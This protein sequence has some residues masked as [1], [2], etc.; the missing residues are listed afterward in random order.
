[1]NILDLIS[2]IFVPLS[3]NN[4]E[5]RKGVTIYQLLLLLLKVAG[6]GALGYL[7]VKLGI[8]NIN[9]INTVIDNLFKDNVLIKNIVTYIAMLMPLLALAVLLRNLGVKE[10]PGLVLL[11]FAIA[12]LTYVTTKL[13]PLTLLISSLFAIGLASY[14]YAN[15]KEVTE[16]KKERKGVGEKWW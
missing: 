2:V 10:N 13:L 16:I 12:Y 5:K 8:K 9:E 6:I 15:A 11:G 7:A 1:M 3:R 4:A 14:T